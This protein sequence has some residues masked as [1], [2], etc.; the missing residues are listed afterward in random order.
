METWRVRAEYL[1]HTNS[2]QDQHTK[3]SNKYIPFV[4]DAW[5]NV[6]LQ[7]DTYRYPGFYKKPTQEY[8]MFLSLYVLS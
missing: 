7:K 8:N 1:M 5:V 2:T 6:N 4:L 3:M